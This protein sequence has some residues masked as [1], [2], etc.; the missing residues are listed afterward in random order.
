MI[1]FIKVIVLNI[2]FLF[3]ICFYMDLFA[4][5]TNELDV[6]IRESKFVL[7]EM[8]EMPDGAIPMDL[9]NNCSGVV[10][11]PS[12]FNVGFGLGGFYGKGVLLRK[13]ELTG[14]WSAPVFMR[15]SGGT[16]GLQLGIQLTDLILIIMNNRAVNNI[17]CNNFVLGFDSSV[18]FGPV[19]RSV[20]ASTDFLLKT[21]IFAYSRNR[22]LF[23][24]VSFKGAKINAI[25]DYNKFYYGENIFVDDILFTNKVKIT[26]EGQKLIKV[27]KR[28]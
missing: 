25:E 10:I 15:I 3:N 22:G 2:F 4:L 14:N 6:R 1:Q 18:A 19:G 28:S 27:L 13:D 16:I 20:T 17:S 8:Q 7:E 12:V 5:S 9:L 24:G 11:F 21:G 26:N 23:L